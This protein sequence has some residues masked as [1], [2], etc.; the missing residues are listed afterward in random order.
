MGEGLGTSNSPNIG[1]DSLGHLPES[2]ASEG[3]FFAEAELNENNGGQD[4]TDSTGYEAHRHPR[5]HEAGSV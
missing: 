3:S 2:E 1:G 5:E 4:D